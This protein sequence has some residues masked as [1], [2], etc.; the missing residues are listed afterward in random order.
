MKIL[1]V[2]FSSSQ[3]S[4]AVLETPGPGKLV[5]AE[6]VEAGPVENRP[7]GM[8]EQALR[9]AG[10][11]REQ[12][13]LLV[14]GLGPGSYTGIRA[15]ISLGQGWQLAN[16]VRLLGISSA[17][18]IAAQGYAEGI[19]GP[20]G[21]MIDAQRN[22]FYVAEYE[23]A[24]EG[25]REL[26]PLKLATFA[27]VKSLHAAGEVLIGPEVTKWFPGTRQVFPWAVTL[28]RLAVARRDFVAGDKLQPIYL[29]ETKFVKAAP[30]RRLG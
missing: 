10:L 11:E 22:E 6:V 2:E 7:L 24:G 28:G 12:V 3:R 14:I 23:L 21:V 17:E 19:R 1:A 27:D 4:V 29:R 8:I 30:P 9:E 20:I 26:A 15:A 25:W 5:E 16:G 18:C 13:E